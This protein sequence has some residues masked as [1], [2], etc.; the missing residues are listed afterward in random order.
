MRI[1]KS[2][3]QQ[4]PYLK[5]RMCVPNLLKFCI[6]IKQHIRKMEEI[7]EKLNGC[8]FHHI[9]SNELLSLYATCLGKYNESR[10]RVVVVTL[11]SMSNNPTI[12]TVPE[13]LAVG[14]PHEIQFCD[15]LLLRPEVYNFTEECK[16]LPVDGYATNATENI[17]QLQD[18]IAR[19]PDNEIA[20]TNNYVPFTSD[21]LLILLRKPR[22]HKYLLS[23]MQSSNGYKPTGHLHEAIGEWNTRIFDKRHSH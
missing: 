7:M 12:L 9:H 6:Y 23:V 15:M 20:P 14:I 18:T 19:L 13:I 3:V 1:N 10:I 4:G 11:Q 5:V 21:R 2:I 17:N 8:K 16:T 22:N